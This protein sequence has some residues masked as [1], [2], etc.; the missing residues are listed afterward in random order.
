ML[1]PCLTPDATHPDSLPD[2]THLQQSD[3][4]LPVGVLQDVID[5]A[6]VEH[7]LFFTC[8]QWAGLLLCAT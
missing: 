3:L 6:D 1:P 7:T 4:Q 2:T 5:D 8:K